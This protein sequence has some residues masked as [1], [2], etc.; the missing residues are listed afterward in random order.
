MTPDRAWWKEAIVYQIYPQSFNDSDGDGVGDLAGIVEKLDYLEELGVDVVWLNPVYDSPHH[1]DGYDVRDYRAI[2]EEYGT[3]AEWEALL[4]GLHDRDMRLIMDLVVNHTSDEH[5]W[6]VA[7][8]ERDP[9]YADYY[10]W[11]DGTPA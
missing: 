10:I 9:D 11:K 7:S 6:F 4:E 3:M 5:E 2:R 1:D 8:R